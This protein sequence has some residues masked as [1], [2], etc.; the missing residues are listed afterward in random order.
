M[1]MDALAIYIVIMVIFHIK[2]LSSPGL[3]PDGKNMWN[4]IIYNL[5]MDGYGPVLGQ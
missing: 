4:I 2:L 3:K 1:E 5:Y